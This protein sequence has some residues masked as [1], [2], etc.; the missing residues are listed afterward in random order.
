MVNQFVCTKCRKNISEAELSV[1]ESVKTRYDDSVHTFCPS[2]DTH[3]VSINNDAYDKCVTNITK[4]LNRL[5]CN[6]ICYYEGDVLNGSN[7]VEYYPPIFRMSDTEDRFFYRLMSMIKISKDKLLAD[8]QVIDE[9]DNS[10][11]IV[12]GTESWCFNEETGLSNK[13]T[14]LAIMKH[15]IAILIECGK[16]YML[17]KVS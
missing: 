5:G 2:C 8:V 17:H 16:K 3:I 15:L 14:H 12:V 6:L 10:F 1:A 9:G 4:L 13:R 11:S 7:S